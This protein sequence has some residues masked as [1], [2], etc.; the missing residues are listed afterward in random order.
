MVA[1]VGRL[2]HE[3]KHAS[4]ALAR[5]QEAALSAVKCGYGSP[6]LAKLTEM[7]CQLR[8]CGLNLYVDACANPFGSQIRLG[9]SS[10]SSD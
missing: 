3:S 6:L 5:E 8:S 10:S 7:N 9:Q 4:Q 2:E 1:E